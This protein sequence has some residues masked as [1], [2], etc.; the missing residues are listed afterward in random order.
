MTASTE[1]Q[2]E[3]NVW[4]AAATLRARCARSP[5]YDVDGAIDDHRASVVASLRHIW[6]PGVCPLQA[7]DLADQLLLLVRRNGR[8]AE[9][10][11]PGIGCPDCRRT[12]DGSADRRA[13]ADFVAAELLDIGVGLP[14]WRRRPGSGASSLRRRRTRCCP[15]RRSQPPFGRVR[16]QASSMLSHF[17]L[18]SSQISGAAGL[19]VF[20]SKVSAPPAK[21]SRL[22]SQA[23][24]PP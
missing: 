16:A 17:P 20:D 18:R 24:A 3:D 23:A 8:A 4:L 19:G 15:Y 9:Y 11:G 2:R 6:P 13:V 14:G 22:P 1:P 5:S 10:A 12:L 21:T 7:L